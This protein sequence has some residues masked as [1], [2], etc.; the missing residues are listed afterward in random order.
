MFGFAFLKFFS[1]PQGTETVFVCGMIGL[2]EDIHRKKI[3]AGKSQLCKTFH[4]PLDKI[5][6]IYIYI[7]SIY[8]PLWNMSLFPCSW[9]C[10]GWAIPAETTLLFVWW[11]EGNANPVVW[12]LSDTIK[13]VE[14][15]A[16][17]SC[18]WR[19]LIRSGDWKY[20]KFVLLK[21]I[22]LVSE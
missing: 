13:W 21:L 12:L 5:I 2:V 18:N 8:V 17:P 16:T 20:L 15:R 22:F 6:Y 9:H 14:K 1:Q 11:R 7:Y 19:F 4:I 3:L 10:R